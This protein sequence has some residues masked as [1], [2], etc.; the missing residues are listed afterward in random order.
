MRFYAKLEWSRRRFSGSK[1]RGLASIDR[2][3]GRNKLTI[4][5]SGVGYGNWHGNLQLALH[6]PN[7]WWVKMLVWFLTQLVYELHGLEVIPIFWPQK[8]VANLLG[9][10]GIIEPAD[11]WKN[12]FWYD[13]LVLGIWWRGS[14]QMVFGCTQPTSHCLIPWYTMMWFQS[15]AM[16]YCH[17]YHDVDPVKSYNALSDIP[18]CGPS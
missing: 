2:R 18:W 10:G 3:S 5:L 12:L 16:M 8:V 9:V 1:S 11:G 14:G 15:T 13:W 7:P 17:I 4:I 6:L